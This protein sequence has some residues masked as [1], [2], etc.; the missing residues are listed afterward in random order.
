[1]E[2]KRCATIRETA[3]GSE[4]REGGNCHH[5]DP[6]EIPVLGEDWA[7]FWLVR[8]G[9]GFPAR[10]KGRPECRWAEEGLALSE[11]NGKWVG[12]C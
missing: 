4:E 3:G 12:G 1:M 8:A 9:R 7:H 5:R 10:R 11:N 2:L 6:Q